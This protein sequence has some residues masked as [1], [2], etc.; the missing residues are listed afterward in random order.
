MGTSSTPPFCAAFG[1]RP[2]LML[3][4][5]NLGVLQTTVAELVTVKEHQREYPRISAGVRPG[6]TMGS[7]CICCYANGLVC[8]V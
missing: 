3:S 4:V 7:S 5:S 2:G 6:L 1:C 8:R